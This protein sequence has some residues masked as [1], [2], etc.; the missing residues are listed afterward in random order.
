MLD[1]KQ[2]IQVL[3]KKNIVARATCFDRLDGPFVRALANCPPHPRLEMT[4]ELIR[5]RTG[6]RVIDSEHWRQDLRENP[7]SEL[8]NRNC[9]CRAYPGPRKQLLQC[10][11]SF[12]L[13]HSHTCFLVKD[14]DAWR[15]RGAL[16]VRD[17]SAWV[18]PHHNALL[19]RF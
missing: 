8:L 4:S 14:V 6:V 16:G 13:E 9:L 3:Y 19:S 7:S 5:A 1:D 18:D 10:G 11:V 17:A 12:I 2:W 15:R